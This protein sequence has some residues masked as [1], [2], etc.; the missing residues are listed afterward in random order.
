MALDMA[1]ARA[2]IVPATLWDEVDIEAWWRPGADVTIRFDHLFARRAVEPGRLEE[3][4][5]IGV[6]DRGQQQSV[7][8]PRR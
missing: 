7:S 5:G 4:D 1:R 3:N 8:A 2:E 6:A